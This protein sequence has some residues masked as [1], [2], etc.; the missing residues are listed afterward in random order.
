MLP[1][2]LISLYSSTNYSEIVNSHMNVLR[3]ILLI[4]P[5]NTFTYGV[6]IATLKT[7]ALV[8]VTVF[9]TACSAVAEHKQ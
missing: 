3:S 2:H 6:F 8:G 4:K 7:H 1:S 9:C 5:F